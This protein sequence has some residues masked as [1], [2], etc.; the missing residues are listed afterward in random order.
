MS[1]VIQRAKERAERASREATLWS[2][3]ANCVLKGQN[4]KSRILI[5]DPAKRK[6][7][8]CPRRSGKSHTCAG[9]A[10]HVGESN[11]GARILIISITLKSTRENYWSGA[12][13]GL[14]SQG[15]R[16][17]LNLKFNNTD[18][19]WWHEN[20][21]RGR[22]AGAETKADIEYLRGAAV[23][24]DLIIVDECQSFSPEHLDDLIRNVL[25]PGLMTR[26]GTLLLAGT[27]GLIPVG[28]Y[29]E[30][31]EPRHR[32]SA[33]P[34]N[35]GKEIS[36]PTCIYYPDREAE[37]YKSLTHKEDYWSLHTW[38]LQDNEAVLEQWNRALATKRRNK[39][40]D[41][42]PTWRR[43][44]L[45]E[46]VTDESGLVYAYGGCRAKGNVNWLPNW[47]AE[48]VRSNGK[49]DRR[50]AVY[51]SNPAGLPLD[52][53]PWH[54]IMGLDFGFEDDCAVVVAAYSDQLQ[55]LFHVDDY[56]SP[57]LTADD[58]ALEV[59]HMIDR[60]GPPDIIVADAGGLGKM[61]IATLNQRYGMSII[62]AEKKEK[63][64]HIEL[65]N[66]DFHCGRIKIQVGSDLERE[67][68]GLQYDLSQ[69]RKTV[70]AR[71]GKLREDPK[72]PNHLCDA[73]LYLW[74]YAY[75]YWSKLY[76]LEPVRGTPEFYKRAE[77]E[78]IEKA[79][80]RKNAMS[81]DPHGFRRCAADPILGDPGPN[82]SRLL[83]GK[84]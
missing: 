46:W 8:R 13:A 35:T 31:S 80:A 43:E 44:Y 70:L 5:E 23:E 62:A 65:L 3:R 72:C 45:G 15:Y 56:K 42:H 47:P 64:D 36:F 20:G 66:S 59:Q 55:E 39:W 1:W 34:E 16:F 37:Q 83:K 78:A 58:F 6:T 21:A 33:D 12:P 18:Y 7:A 69:E 73:F 53:G 54:F 14:Q 17:G 71:M 60:Y 22:L 63:F 49:V 41:D 2:E 74:R 24:A 29:F 11:P 81:K 68:L 9:Y 26:G 77:E 38:T 4:P 50:H 52:K 10:L 67:M 75:H 30:A 79:V 28:P 25:E 61:V 48:C 19:V 32:I 51:R 82:I 76:D 57:H 84:Q 27:P 40:A